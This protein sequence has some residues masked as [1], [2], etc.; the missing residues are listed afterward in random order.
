MARELSTGGPYEAPKVT[1]E[2]TGSLSSR[3]AAP[4]QAFVPFWTRI[5]QA[6]HVRAR[7]VPAGCRRPPRAPMG[8]SFDTTEA[9][10]GWEEASEGHSHVLTQSVPCSR[11]GGRDGLQNHRKCCMKSEMLPLIEWGDTDGARRAR[12]WPT[13]ACFSLPDEHG[14]LAPSLSALSGSKTR[15]DRTFPGKPARPCPYCV[16]GPQKELQRPNGP[17]KRRVRLCGMPK[18]GPRGKDESTLAKRVQKLHF[19]RNLKE[20]NQ[21]KDNQKRALQ[22]T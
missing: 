9:R 20:K 15:C 12:T 2:A 10:G 1:E 17:S 4:L 19:G 21:E 8:A 3:R 5:Q 7:A 6:R 18:R 11:T 13:R 16:R 14:G 22:M